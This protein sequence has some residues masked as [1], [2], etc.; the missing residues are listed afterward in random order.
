MM[1]PDGFHAFDHRW[2]VHK[3][4]EFQ[5]KMGRDRV[6]QRTTELNTRLKNS[7]EE[8]DGVELLTPMDPTLSAGINCFIVGKLSAGE[9]VQ[10]MHT[11]HVIAS[12]SPY[13]VSYPRLTPCVINTEDEV[14]QS[15]EALKEVSKGI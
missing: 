13:L 10:R 11:K 14:D 6:H 2:S 9:V 12:A 3:A 7:V 15:L 8:M 5:T 1:T 4:L